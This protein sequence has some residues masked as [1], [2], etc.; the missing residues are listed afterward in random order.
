MLETQYEQERVIAELHQEIAQQSD[1]LEEL[2][3]D[4]FVAYQDCVFYTSSG[5][6]FSYTVKKKKNGD[7]SGERLVSR[8]ESSKTLTKSSIFLAFHKVLG[9][10]EIEDGTELRFPEYKGPKAIGQIFGISYIYSI[11]E[12]SQA[13]KI[14]YGCYYLNFLGMAKKIL[15]Y[16]N[17]C[18]FGQPSPQNTANFRMFIIYW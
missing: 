14:M 2:L 8:K 3:W 12:C 10:I 11:Y 1:N 9:A 7:Y 18:F 16:E 13:K 5:L 6:P 17:L 15:A 4:C